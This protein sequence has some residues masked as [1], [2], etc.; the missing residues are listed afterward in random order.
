MSV[1]EGSLIHNT[2]KKRFGEVALRN[3]KSR[4][5]GFPHVDG[6]IKTFEYE[7]ILDRRS[8]DFLRVVGQEYCKSLKSGENIVVT[9][10]AA[11]IYGMVRFLKRFAPTL[12]IDQEYDPGV[13][14]QLIAFEKNR[15][16]DR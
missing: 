13:L 7:V 15:L 2:Y 9:V 1:A 6:S 4:L 3:S 14:P 8:I 10:G 5:L 12:S 16:G 11:H